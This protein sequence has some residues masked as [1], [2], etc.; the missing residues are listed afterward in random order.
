[1][2]DALES[3]YDQRVLNCIESAKMKSVKDAFVES[4]AN[5]HTVKET[6]FTYNASEQ[7]DIS[8]AQSNSKHLFT[9]E[10]I[11]FH[12]DIQRRYK[13]S[14]AETLIYGFIRFFL[15]NSSNSFYFSNQQ[16]SELLDVSERTV[17][18]SIKNLNKKKVL[19]VRYKRKSDGGQI[20]FVKP[21][22]QFGELVLDNLAS[23]KRT[24][25]LG[26]NNKIN[27]NSIN[28]GSLKK[29]V[30][31]S[32]RPKPKTVDEVLANRHAYMDLKD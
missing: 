4:T 24:K 10:F 27:K 11:P 18:R 8:I 3:G 29:D 14:L 12:I 30:D 25:S 26:N 15:K 28:K 13:L 31:N 16:I 20:R 23:S 22:G 1:M 17:S 9:P 5:G 32:P 19:A 2:V 7:E 6:L 21:T